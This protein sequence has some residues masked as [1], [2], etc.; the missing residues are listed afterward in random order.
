ML[1]VKGL[2]VAIQHQ[3]ILT[4]ITFT[5]P[6]GSIT[7]LIGHNGAGKSTIMKTIKGWQEKKKG[8][9]HLNHMD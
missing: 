2:Q 4:D 8:Q 5:L 3:P 9:I 1:D 7:A 6:Q